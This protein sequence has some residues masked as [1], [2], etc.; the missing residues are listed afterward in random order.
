MPAAP[1]DVIDLFERFRQSIDTGS[2]PSYNETQFRRGLLLRFKH[3]LPTVLLAHW[4]DGEK[5]PW[6]LATNLSSRR[7]TLR[8][9]RR[10][11]WIE[12]MFDDM[13]GNG[14]DLA[15]TLLC[16]FLR[17]SRLTNA[18]PISNRLRPVCGCKL[19]GS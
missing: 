11:M 3:T 16:H 9:Y 17:L 19:S 6:L 8:A 14:F 10:R 18:T 5:G 13:K 12:E 7:E 2:S 1:P 15:S 4:K